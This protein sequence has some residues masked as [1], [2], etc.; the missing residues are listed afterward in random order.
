ME[1]TDLLYYRQHPTLHI[2]HYRILIY[3]E[4]FKMLKYNNMFTHTY[5]YYS[6]GKSNLNNKNEIDKHKIKN[7]IAVYL[8]IHSL[9]NVQCQR[10]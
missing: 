1:L 6:E 5:I 3:D 10:T 4:R 2:L 9:F 8:F 7:L